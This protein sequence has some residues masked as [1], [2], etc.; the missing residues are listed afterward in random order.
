MRL[1]RRGKHSTT[2][3]TATN[4]YKF[5]YIGLEWYTP[6][7]EVR[8]SDLFLNLNTYSWV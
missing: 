4:L 7:L 2:R 6:L 3:V 1:R 5:I 8:T